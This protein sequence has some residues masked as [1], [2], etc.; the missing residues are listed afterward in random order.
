MSEVISKNIN[1]TD[2]DT[3][4]HYNFNSI[5][6]K[7]W[8]VNLVN[9]LK[10]E[11]VSIKNILVRKIADCGD[12]V[13]INSFKSLED[14]LG[15]FDRIIFDNSIDI[16]NIRC[17]YNNIDFIICVNARLNHVQIQFFDY[18]GEITFDNIVNKAMSK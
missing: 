3:I 4:L 8:I 7:K 1:F 5:N 11:S 6:N 15:A 12:G 17:E 13:D 9:T 18:K 10:E 2:T 14:Y 16:V